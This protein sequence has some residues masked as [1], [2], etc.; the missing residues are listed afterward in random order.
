MMEIC[1]SRQS[2]KEQDRAT[3][4]H[5]RDSFREERDAIP[6]VPYDRELMG[7]A[8]VPDL[9]GSFVQNRAQTEI[10]DSMLYTDLR[11][12]G[13]DE[14][15]SMHFM[16]AFHNRANRFLTTDMDFIDR[17][18]ELEE[19]CPTIRICTPSQMVAELDESLTGV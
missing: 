5:I 1:T 19:R 15:D 2:W 7:G 14:G 10:I 12:I 17:A 3:N 16:Y 11:R 6:V 8:L 13:L 9:T 4:R 18:K